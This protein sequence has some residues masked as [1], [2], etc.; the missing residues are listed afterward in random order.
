V[1]AC[2]RSS[3]AAA[4]PPPPITHHSIAMTRLHS[5]LLA[6][7]AL[8]LTGPLGAQ[9]RLTVFQPF[10]TSTT[11][12]VD[13]AGTIVNTWP[14]IATPGVN[15]DLLPNGDLVR[16]LNLTNRIAG[17]GGGFERLSYDGTL[18]WQFRFFTPK[19]TP[20]HDFVVLP[21]GNVILTVYEEF[22]VAEAIALGRDPAL[23]GPEPFLP[24][25]LYEITQTG[26]TTGDVVWEWHAVDHVIQD[27]DPLAANYGVLADNPQLADIDAGYFTDWM[28][29][30]GIDYNA[31]LD[32]IAISVPTFN[33]V[34]V[35]D[36]STTTVEA[37]G[38]TGG[39]SGK[40]GDI[41]YRWGNPQVY[42]RGTAA[43]Q[44]FYFLHDVQWVA[45]GLPGAGNLMVFNNG[46]ARPTGSWS[47]ADE[48]TPPTPDANGNY[49]LPPSA[50]YGPAGLS[51]TYADQANFYSN[52]MGGVQRL[53][54]GNTRICE[55]TSGLVFEVDTFGN[56]L[57]G[58]TNTIGTPN[59]LFKTRS[60]LDC[61]ANGIYDREEIVNGGGDFDG[62]D[63]LDA[64]EPPISYCSAAL[65]SSGQAAA[66]NW[67]GSTNISLNDFVLYADFCPANAFGVFAVSSGQANVPFGDGTL[68]IAAPVTRLGAAGTNAIGSA[69]IS[70]DNYALTPGPAT[71]TPG[72]VRYFTYFFRDAAGGPAGFNLSNGLAVVF[73]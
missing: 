35:I 16:A 15:V 69:T 38:H 41:L 28:H 43:D 17:S 71:I 25:A 33:E 68:C 9:Q 31:E 12:L 48:F 61:N 10:S 32:Q 53:E 54:N 46:N 40:G 23:L 39:N 66:M 50:A 8:A 4:A 5:L 22:S 57:W 7:A 65:N 3:V 60:Y 2:D 29:V 55:S 6:G 24:D 58:Y 49:P 1:P 11:Y 63:V 64:C 42:G 45:D 56:R 30:N 52:I 27:R 18:E 13:D 51:W 37:A 47:S 21:N 62:N 73:L 70:V 67:T 14:G 36:H 19:L 20:H 44:V 72:S 26:P 59:W 34:W